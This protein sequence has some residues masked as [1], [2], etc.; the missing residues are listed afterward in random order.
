[1]QVARQ[2][3]PHICW[4]PN[5]QVCMTKLNC[6]KYSWLRAAGRKLYVT[7]A[8]KLRKALPTVSSDT[9][10]FI[11]HSLTELHDGPTSRILHA[12]K[13]VLPILHTCNLAT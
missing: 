13:V 5:A 1:M 9:H 12:L 11:T 10:R 8:Y 7:K 6:H 4:A 3:E 2:T